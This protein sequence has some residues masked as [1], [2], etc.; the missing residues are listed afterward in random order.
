[1]SDHDSPAVSGTVRAVV[2]RIGPSESL[3]YCDFCFDSEIAD[4]HETG[5]LRPMYRLDD[6]CIICQR[7]LDVGKQ[8]AEA[9][10]SP[11]SVDK[12]PPLVRQSG[13]AS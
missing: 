7:C 4:C 9:Q 12:L 6:D 5:E 2:V 10:R 3:L 8:N 13:G 11:A 1:M